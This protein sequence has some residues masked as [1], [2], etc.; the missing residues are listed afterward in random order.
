M[1][2]QNGCWNEELGT[3]NDMKSQELYSADII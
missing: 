2:I 3:C 1:T